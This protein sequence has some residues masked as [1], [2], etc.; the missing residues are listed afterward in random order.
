MVTE[1]GLLVALVWYSILA[2]GLW[3]RR[4]WSGTVVPVEGLLVALEWYGLNL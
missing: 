1:E 4:T 3:C 2:G